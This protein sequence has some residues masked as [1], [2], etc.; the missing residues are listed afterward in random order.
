M[1]KTAFI[2]K[3][4]QLDGERR[5]YLV[6]EMAHHL[7]QA[8]RF[9]ELY[10]LIQKDWMDA[11]RALTFSHLSFVS[12]VEIACE[13][14]ISSSPD[15][16]H[17]ARGRLIV[18]TLA[19]YATNVPPEVLAGLARFGDVDRAESYIQLIRDKNLQARAY[20]LIGKVLQERGMKDRAAGMMRKAS[21]IIE[22]RTIEESASQPT[23]ELLAAIGSGDRNAMGRYYSVT[24]FPVPRFG[25]LESK[26]RQPSDQQ[27]VLAEALQI[28]EPAKKAGLLIDVARTWAISGDK[29]K[30]LE[31][32]DAVIA[33][34]HFQYWPEVLSQIALAFISLQE[35]EETMI[36]LDTLDSSNA[37]NVVM[38]G[39]D[40]ETAGYYA[41]DYGFAIYRLEARLASL[42][43]AILEKLVTEMA[44]T[45]NKDDLERVIAASERIGIEEDLDR[46]TAL[47]ALSKVFL[48]RKECREYAASPNSGNGDGPTR[49]QE[50]FAS[51]CISLAH[52]GRFEDARRM[53]GAIS[54][55]QLRIEVQGR[56]ICIQLKDGD[57][58]GALKALTKVNASS[59]AN[60]KASV[61]A[62]V[63]KVARSAADL[64]VMDVALS[65][66]SSLTEKYQRVRILTDAALAFV[67]MGLFDKA[68]SLATSIA[69]E[70][71]EAGGQKRGKDEK[72]DSYNFLLT[73]R[74]CEARIKSHVSQALADKGDFDAALVVAASIPHDVFVADNEAGIADA[75]GGLSLHLAEVGEKERLA[76]V[77]GMVK[78]LKSDW[79]K[80]K[81]LALVGRAY[82]FLGEFSYASM[83]ADDGQNTA[84]SDAAKARVAAAVAEEKF[85]R[86]L[87]QGALTDITLIK[88]V[89]IKA[90]CI[91]SIASTITHDEKRW[92]DDLL[93]AA[94]SIPDDR[95]KPIAINGVARASARLGDYQRLNKAIIAADQLQYDTQKAEAFEGLAAISTETTDIAGF[96]LLL[97]AIRRLESD[98]TRIK[99]VGAAA[100]A[101]SIMGK[102]D[103]LTVLWCSEFERIKSSG[104]EAIF[105]L[106][107]VAAS[108]LALIDNGQLLSRIYQEIIDVE[109]W[110]SLDVP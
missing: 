40:E 38:D 70:G 82:A 19:S 90:L 110:W 10:L 57:T 62:A 34:K 7:Y 98:W 68:L 45:S 96:N 28:S 35:Y 23:N 101:L 58:N 56:L 33:D 104:R 92:L 81:A 79:D 51:T 24:E 103:R 83:I 27:V 5:A 67:R 59:D 107:S 9:E 52:L 72:K 89:E 105:Y 86:G 48:G 53:F 87:F 18:S 108:S 77:L 75:L 60:L 26:L 93:L 85:K 8:A 91:H 54:N 63:S 21:I 43:E 102:Y 42:R 15:I 88:D 14:A 39:V 71:G 30:I 78:A 37:R 76:T 73:C 36:L 106:L 13:A 94:D 109:R 44:Q 61:T 55:Y 12:D 50:F 46:N 84:R 64:A 41:M 32:K 47:L 97:T 100:D 22:D 66:I 31:L 49:K 3:L 95:F 2:N 17:Y 11:K 6:E 25:D 80:P 69:D 65:I 99:A 4:E 29:G 1:G 16:I 20:Q 74:G